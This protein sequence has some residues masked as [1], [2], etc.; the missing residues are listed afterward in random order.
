M[1]IL[2]GDRRDMLLMGVYAHADIADKG[3]R[4]LNSIRHLYGYVG[5]SRQM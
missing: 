5:L 3:R 4:V 1:N 2:I